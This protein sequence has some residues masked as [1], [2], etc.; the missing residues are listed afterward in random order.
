[1]LIVVLALSKEREKHKRPTV[2]A[3]GC[4]PVFNRSCAT[5]RR[6]HFITEHVI[7]AIDFVLLDGHLLLTNPS[8]EIFGKFV[9]C[10]HSENDE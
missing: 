10:Y 6:K 8:V 5:T 1:M 3:I 9:I 4:I 7:K 2:T